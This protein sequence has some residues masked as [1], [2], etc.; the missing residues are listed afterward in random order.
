MT[1]LESWLLESWLLLFPDAP[2]TGDDLIARWSEP[3]RH[4]HTTAHLERMLSIVDSAADAA[5]DI[6]A[7]RLAA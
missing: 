2:A 1:L 3:Q 7:V 6:V 5:E 4:Y